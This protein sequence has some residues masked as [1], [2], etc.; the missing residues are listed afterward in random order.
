V[1]VFSDHKNLEYFATTKVLNRRQ[2][3]W[4]QELAGIDFKTFFRPGVQNGKPDA[5][6]RRSEYR[7]AKGGSENQPIKTILHPHHFTGR[8]SAAGPGTTFIIS[9]A[10]LSGLPVKKWSESFVD[11]VVTTGK[12]D[13]A[14]LE[15]LT[16]LAELMES[17]VGKAGEDMDYEMEQVAAP[18]SEEARGEPQGQQARKG[19]GIKEML[20]LQQGMLYREGLLWLPNDTNI[21]KTVLESEHDSKIAGHMGRDKTIEIFRRNFWWPKM[22]AQIIDFVQSCPDCQKDK[23][24][25]HHPSGMLH[26]LELPFAPWQSIAIDF[27][28][29]LPLSDNC[30]QLWVVIDRFTK[31]AHFLPLKFERRQDGKRSRENFRTRDLASPRDAH[32]HRLRQR[33]PI[34][35]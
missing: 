12:K 34:H 27:I 15:A 31:M 30:D 26:P 24:A 25:H 35:V 20:S 5:L 21:I 6:S 14:Y 19:K 28:T 3:R 2:A 11:Q 1:Q 7:P 32:R 16:E 29:D 8:I 13:K 4:A 23:A 10:Q 22:D 17:D 9:G 18:A 33:L